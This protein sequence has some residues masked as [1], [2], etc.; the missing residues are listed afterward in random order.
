MHGLAGEE[1]VVEAVGPQSA[2]F[3]PLPG[4]PAKRSAALTAAGAY[5]LHVRLSGAAVAGW[6]R[7]LHATAAASEASR[8]APSALNARW[9]RSS[10]RALDYSSQAQMF[11]GGARQSRS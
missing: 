5:L 2:T 7:A 3:A 10:D 6:P 9:Q 8:C 1:V 11:V 4:S